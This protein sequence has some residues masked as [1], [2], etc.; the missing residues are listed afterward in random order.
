MFTED[1]K[2]I[3]IELKTDDGSTRDSQYRYYYK[4]IE[5]GFQ[6]IIQ[7]VLDI[8]D[9]TEYKHKYLR[10]INKLAEIG[11]LQMNSGQYVATEKYSFFPSPVFIKPNRKP[12]DEG[13]VIEF[14]QIVECFK[15]EKNE[16][17]KRFVESLIKW[18]EPTGFRAT[19]TA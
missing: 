19:T 17:T 16:V 14:S 13:E 12:D 1:H 8:F 2:V 7:G 15:A 18:T 9:K 4:A 6:K 3:L 11:S 10:L 5:V